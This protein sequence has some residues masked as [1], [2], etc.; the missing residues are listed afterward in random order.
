MHSF[1]DLFELLYDETGINLPFLY[2]P[3]FRAKIASGV[4]TTISLAFWSLILSLIIGCVGSWLQRARFSLIRW[5]VA[6]Y[7]QVFRNTPPLV[8]IYFF[9]FAVSAFLPKVSNDWGGMEPM[10]GAFAWAVLSLSLFAGAFNIEIF[11]SGMEAV[12]QSTIEAA[13]T[14]GFTRLQVFLHVSFPLAFRTSLPALTNNLV[15]LVKS[16]TLAYAIAVPEM[17]Y[18]AGEV[19][20]ENINVLEMM[21]FLLLAYYV[22][23][24]ILVRLMRGVERALKIPG[25]GQ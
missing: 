20:A 1:F 16:T 8:Q 7:I 12:P 15:N 25:M 9:Y 24:G 21:C 23:V 3:Y 2:D 5:A 14:L 10:V 13:E 17:L 11:R 22:L 4:L 19:W 6:V 18:R